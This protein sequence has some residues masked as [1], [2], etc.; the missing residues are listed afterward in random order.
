M[1]ARRNQSCKPPTTKWRLATR[2]SGRKGNPPPWL[3]PIHVC[4]WIIPDLRRL[5]APTPLSTLSRWQMGTRSAACRKPDDL[6]S[7]VVPALGPS[8]TG[9]QTGHRD[10]CGRL[11]RCRPCLHRSSGQKAKRAYCSPVAP[12]GAAANP[13]ALPGRERRRQKPMWN[14]DVP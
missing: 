6:A 12:C 7:C 9:C 4:P 10:A 11:A 1:R 13:R 8:F 5:A 3:R 2:R 14:G